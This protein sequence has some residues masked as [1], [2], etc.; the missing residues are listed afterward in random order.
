MNRVRWTVRVL[1]L[2]GAAS[3]ALLCGESPRLQALVPAS[4]PYL[5][6]LALLA[7]GGAGLMLLPAAAAAV[8]SVL[9]PRF[10][11]RWICPAG[12]CFEA[13]G[14]AGRVLNRNAVS[15]KLPRM[16]L[17][18]LGIG[19]GAA[20]LGYPL[21]LALDP[22]ALFSAAFI[23]AGR[24]ANAWE[25]AAA[26]LFPVLIV[27]AVVAPGVW[28]GRLC[29]LGALQDLL[30]AVRRW[31][32]GLAGSVQP[33]PPVNSSLAAG[34]RVFLGLG[35]GAAYR[36]LLRPA[37]A[38]P[39]QPVI[40]PPASGSEARFTRLCARCGACARACPAKIIRQGGM[41]GGFAGV[42]APELD[43]MRGAC[44]PECLRCGQA[45]P[46]GAIPQF[47]ADDK[48]R[49]PLGTAVVKKELCVLTHDREC[50]VCMHICP[51]RAI[52]IAWDPVGMTSVLRVSSKRCT[53]C[54]LCQY[55]CPE[56]PRAI[57]VER[58]RA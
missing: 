41:E 17:W 57:V 46:T 53:G 7:G 32:A 19:A 36:L 44:G 56:E 5:A 40:R 22:L 47:S 6:L 49:Y 3:L 28:C 48:F 34:R 43:F 29:P 37:G 4:S 42:L 51:H 31:M 58:Q 30:S 15:P 9:K 23:G 26:A 18:L 50:G 16:G 12:T 25:M 39:R 38:Q 11:C 35:I 13:A 27:V 21:F 20:L 14:Q 10:F 54:G 24:A 45:C 1:L 2:A 52:G 55:V 33:R 8:A